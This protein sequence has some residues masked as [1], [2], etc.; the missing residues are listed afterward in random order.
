MNIKLLFLFAAI[1]VLPKTVLG[2]DSVVYNPYMDLYNQVSD[3]EVLSLYSQVDQLYKN[4]QNAVAK[5]QSTANKLLGAIAI[6]AGGIGGMMLASGLAERAADEDAERDMAAYIATFK[7]DYGQGM[8][9]KGGESNI[10]LPGANV[11]L[12]IYNEYIAL[13][14]DLKERKEAL[15][16]SLG[17]ESEIILNAA[18]TGLY[19][20]ES[21]GKT[22][23]AYASI[24]RALMDE[25]S[26]DAKELDA[27]TAETNKQIKTGAIVGG[28]GLGVG[29][30]G[31]AVIN[32][33]LLNKSQ[34]TKS[35]EQKTTTSK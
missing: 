35:Q 31:D 28:T 34:D 8:N 5:E 13:A 27:Q 4:Y 15:E 14:A 25:N 16:L 20:N 22:D 6:G 29:L 32:G 30:I 7:C 9:I 24:Y 17:I 10:T 2:A 1:T 19:D 23:G 21:T 33:N 18:E 3:L 11:L 26:D 12:P